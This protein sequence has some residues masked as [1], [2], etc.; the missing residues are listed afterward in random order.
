MNFYM[1][2]ESFSNAMQISLPKQAS[3][4]KCF[5]GSV[6]EMNHVILCRRT[7]FFQ[8]IRVYKHRVL[9]EFSAETGISKREKDSSVEMD[10]KHI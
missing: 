4:S 2:N 6:G 7:L 10:I 3:W 8:K 5:Q 9:H 1:S